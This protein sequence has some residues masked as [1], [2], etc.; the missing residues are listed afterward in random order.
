[1]LESG[2]RAERRIDP[3]LPVTLSFSPGHTVLLQG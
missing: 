1:M 2:W 3:Y